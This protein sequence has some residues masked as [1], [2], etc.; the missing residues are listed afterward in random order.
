MKIKSRSSTTRGIG[1]TVSLIILA[2]VFLFNSLQNSSHEDYH[3]SNF[4]KFWVAGHMILTGQNPYDSAQ[5]Y[6]EHIK[7]GATQVPDK[8]FLYPFPQAYFLVPLA[9]IPIAE[10]FIIWGIISQAILAATCFV[11]LNQF[12]KAE[13]YR[14][15]YPLVVFLLFFGPIYLSLQVG[16]IGT[17]ALAV[18]MVAILLLERKKP[19]LAGIVLSVLILKPSQG[20]PI[21]FL[22]GC[23]FLFKQDWKII[24][25]M[26]AGGLILL[27]SGL[28]IEPHWI[29]EFLNNSQAVSDRTLGLQSNIYSFAYLSCN[30][31][32]NCMRIA[33]TIGLIFSLGL[34][35]YYLWLNRERLSTWE[36][37]NIIVPL[38]FVSTI[39]LWSYDQLLYI[40][41]IV[42][43]TVEL[44][45]TTKSYLVAF[46][47][48]IGLDI[49]SFSALAVQAETHTDLLSITT[50]ILIIGLCLWLFHLKNIHPIDKPIP[51]A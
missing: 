31:N 6:N 47:F 43:I 16:S 41:P 24:T 17:I 49:L 26:G 38:G 2:A 36:A 19:L 4:L 40:F 20:L 42:W 18:L 23:W 7:L 29:Q 10:S 39:Y 34:G 51:A 22:A 15:F 9:L 14:L 33:G 35:V 27:L 32:I 1:L 37:I 12:A 5:W 8:I 46:I 28:I 44:V 48:L 25:G 45:K 13:R 11:L 30:K 50:T 3:N 21:L